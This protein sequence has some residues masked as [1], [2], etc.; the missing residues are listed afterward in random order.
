MWSFAIT[1]AAASIRTWV[2]PPG[3]PQTR[4]RHHPLPQLAI[5]PFHRR[6][7]K[8][9]AGR[10]SMPS[11]VRLGRSSKLTT[12]RDALENVSREPEF[13]A[14]ARAQATGRD[15]KTGNWKPGMENGAMGGAF[16]PPFS[17]QHE[18]ASRNS[19]RRRRGAHPPCRARADPVGSRTGWPADDEPWHGCSVT[20]GLLLRRRRWRTSRC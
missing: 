4:P 16:V 1:C 10:M 3:A 17:D 12:A 5:P 13:S 15:W 18:T 14:D 20:W 19:T 7:A 9:R 11:S 2:S 8:T 6:C